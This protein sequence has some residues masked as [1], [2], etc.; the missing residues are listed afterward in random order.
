MHYNLFVPVLHRPTFEQGIKDGLHFQ[1]RGFGAV[2]LLVCANAS[3]VVDDPRVYADGTPVA[4]WQWYEQVEGARWS[5]LEVPC[6]EDLQTF[7]VGVFDE[8]QC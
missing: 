5:Y 2:V 3:R 6:L 1:D 7:A 8:T 4:G